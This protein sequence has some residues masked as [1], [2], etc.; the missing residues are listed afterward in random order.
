[1]SEEQFPFQPGAILHDAIVAAFRANN[2]SFESWLAER[3]VPS[4]TAR[5]ATYG[6]SR[7]PRG[8]ALLK[9]LIEAAGPEM[10]W[11]IYV[12]RLRR[13][14]ADVNGKVA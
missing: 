10:V 1:M 2:G 12:N 11:G 14:V 6:Q 4:A 5:G 9:A 8:T 3:G 7:G 13:H